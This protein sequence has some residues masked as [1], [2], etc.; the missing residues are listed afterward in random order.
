MVCSFCCAYVT[1]HCVCLVAFSVHPTCAAGIPIRF[2]ALLAPSLPSL[3]STPSCLSH[4]HA[5]LDSAERMRRSRAL[6]IG[7][8]SNPATGALP[9]EDWRYQ[10]QLYGNS[11]ADLKHGTAPLAPALLVTAQFSPSSS[12]GRSYAGWLE[13]TCGVDVTYLQVPATVPGLAF[14]YRILSPRVPS[15]QKA[16]AVPTGLYKSRYIT[17]L[18]RGVCGEEGE[19]PEA[20]EGSRTE[21]REKAQENGGGGKTYTVLD[22]DPRMRV[23]SIENVD[24]KDRG[25]EGVREL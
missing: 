6:Y 11:C 7:F 22:V 21:L 4:A 3:C 13:S 10:P 2:Q 16:I 24:V 15:G 8:A 25:E 14:G 9:E 23:A 5:P 19:V 20:P 18:G 1:L 12:E 17:Q